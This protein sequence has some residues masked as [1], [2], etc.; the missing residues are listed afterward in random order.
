MKVRISLLF[1]AAAVTAAAATTTTWEMNSFADFL[2]GRFSNVALS[3]DGRL[4]L[5]PRLDVVFASD[6]P[7]IWS[8][9]R[10]ADGSLF[11][12]TG[13]RGRVYR[14]DANGRGTL[15]WTAEQ[16]Q[17]FALAVDARG[18]LYAGTSPGGQVYRIE[19]GKATEFFN[20]GARYIWALQFA[21]DGSLFVGT[22]DEGKIFRVQ[23]N[24]G[25]EIYYESG[26]S[27]ITALAVDAKG[28]LLAGSEPNGILY[29]LEGPKRAF[30]LYD[31]SLPEIRSILPQ[32]DGTVYVSA[33]GGAV[34][35]RSGNVYGTGGAQGTPAVTAPT[36][37]VT[38]TDTDAQAGPE[39]Q[40]PKPDPTK[41]AA[42]PAPAAAAAQATPAYDLS[43]LIEK[44]AIYKIHP[45]HTV[46]TLWSSKDENI[47]DIA[48]EHD[49]LLFS[50]DL[51]GRIYGLSP[52]RKATLIAQTNEAE[53]MRLLV[54]PAGLLATTGNMGKLYR[55]SGNAAADGYFEAPVHDANT[56]ARWGRLSWRA[57]LPGGTQAAFRTRTGNSARPDNT[58]SDWSAPIADVNKG[59]VTS[60]NARFIQWRV[61]FRSANGAAPS[62]D[63]VTAA[64]LPQNTPPVVRS[65][66]VSSQGGATTQRSGAAPAAAN[67]AFSITVTDTGES[68]QTSAGTPTQ[69][70]NRGTGQQIQ[71]VWQA[72]DPDNDRLVYSLYFRGEDEREWKTL[73]S[74]VFENTFTIDGDALADGRYLFRVSASDRPSN[75]QEYARDAD[76]ISSPV[77]IDNTPPVVRV[78]GIQKTANAVEI[79]V[80]AAD[81]TSP[82]R[83]CEYSL[84]AGPWYP[85][86][87]ADGVTDSP[88]E[89]FRIRLENLRAGEHLL[90][91]RVIDAAGNAGLAKVIVR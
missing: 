69:T 39:V 21:A 73:R 24:G 35:R 61:E 53:A 75:P 71:I 43:G 70:L 19:N 27:H 18:V 2:R 44:S 86:E 12:G 47:Y 45:D 32:Q 37:S 66:S 49:R 40:P 8:I 22:G 57:N 16:P 55:L 42:T 48:L 85:V 46:E 25:S 74:N 76:L 79:P 91:V 28:R 31:S 30:V 90:T 59:L 26:Q 83:R 33:L 4:S 3:R 13:H 72:D 88:V 41:P 15:L 10:G 38:V 89:T 17:V 84:N 87:A 36:I 50:T 58:W 1:A 60:P 78:G 34:A 51:Q 81:Q 11:L 68:P 77:L 5:A 6:Q 80:E 62:V 9:A 64:Y 65:I 14:V 20:P 67:A 82:L 54:S 63:S 29:R 56:V 52:D 23:P 7:E